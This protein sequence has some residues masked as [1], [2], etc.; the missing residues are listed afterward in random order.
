MPNKNYDKKSLSIL[1]LPLGISSGISIG[2]LFG[3][4]AGNIPMGL[5]F[6]VIGGSIIG[7]FGFLVLHSISNKKNK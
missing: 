1:A 7:L 6:G 2:L 5:C 4:V 3:S